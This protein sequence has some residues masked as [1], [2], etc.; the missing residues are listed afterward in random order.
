MRVTNAVA[1]D[2]TVKIT[3][4]KSFILQVPGHSSL[5]IVLL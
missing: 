2:G 1:Y 3:A 4:V 5:K